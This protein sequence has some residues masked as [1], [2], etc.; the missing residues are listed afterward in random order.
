ME[1][2][3]GGLI[4]INDTTFMVFM[5]ME[6]E[7]RKHLTATACTIGIKEM[8]LEEILKDDDVLYYCVN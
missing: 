7:V 3:R 1:V 4:H 5:S 8:L 2:D 6:V